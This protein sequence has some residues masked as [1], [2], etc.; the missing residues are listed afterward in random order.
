MIANEVIV[1]FFTITCW[2]MAE[3][4]EMSSP[5]PADA[6]PVRL[7]ELLGSAW[8][9]F[10]RAG[11]AGFSVAG[12]STPQIRL[13]LAL[14]A[15]PNSRMGDLARRL[16]V[17]ARALTP[18]TD[19]LESEGLIRRVTDVADRRAF[20]LELTDAGGTVATDLAELQADI[21][22]RIFAGLSREQRA[23]LAELLT[24]F[25]TSLD[26]SEHHDDWADA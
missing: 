9:A 15:A 11:Q 22:R 8:R 10:S 24:T 17:T 20:R 7:G 19:G 5:N 4:V 2:S 14:A 21:S 16:G 1:T 13:L 18:I 25:V 6:E 3:A 26:D 12:R 23:Q